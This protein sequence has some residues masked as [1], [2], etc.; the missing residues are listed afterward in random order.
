MGLHG[1]GAGAV[2]LLQLRLM[3]VALLAEGLQIAEVVAAALAK[4][5]DV[6][7]LKDL[8]DGILAASAFAILSVPHEKVIQ[9]YLLF[10][11]KN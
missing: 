3:G 8:D 4:W 11:K 10:L 1:V 5:L 7:H 2:A 6:V 9:I